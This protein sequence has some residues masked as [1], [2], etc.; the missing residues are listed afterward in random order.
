MTAVVALA[1]CSQA[2]VRTVGAYGG[3]PLPRPDHV[4]VGYFAVTPEQVRLDQGVSAR[5]SRAAGDTPLTT[6]Q[7]QAA[8]ATQAALAEALVARLRTYGLPAEI[9]PDGQMPPPG[10]SMMVHGQI[11][12]IDQGNRTRRTLIGLGAGKSS[13]S[14]DA[15]LYYAVDRTAPRF[16]TAF[17]GKD[18]SGRAPGMAETLGAGA[19][20][21]RLATS[22]A[23]GGAMHAGLETR[24]TSDTSEAT[25]LADG[26]AQ[27]IGQFA[28]SQGWIPP[29][30]VR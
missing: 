29:T 2:Q 14:A 6:Q 1:G 20:A 25:K 3:P 17:E 4:L 30:A 5:V 28:A 19:A 27:R 10:T 16:L 13:V 26:L 11:V 7:W 15:Q 12:A 22:A 23:V 9:E 8:Q 21:Q 24:R 18:D